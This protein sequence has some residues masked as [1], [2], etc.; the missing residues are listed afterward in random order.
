MVL[1]QNLP[2]CASAV[3]KPNTT[4]VVIQTPLMPG[5]RQLELGLSMGIMAPTP[6][7]EPCHPPDAHL[8]T[9]LEDSQFNK[10][11]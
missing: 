3:V 8:L 5:P 11:D 9:S 10:F 7:P 1:N 6:P 2:Q 4:A